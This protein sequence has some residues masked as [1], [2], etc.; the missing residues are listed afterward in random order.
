MLQK[1]IQFMLILTVVAGIWMLGTK[2]TSADLVAERKVADNRFSVT[3]LSFVNVNTANLSQLVQFFTT[4]G[5]VPGGFDARTVRIEK[6]GELD[7]KY[8]LQA[9]KKSGDDAFCQ[10]LGLKIARRDLSVI[11]EGDLFDLSIQDTLQD[12]DLEEWIIL[13][14]FDHTDEDLKQKTCEFDLY[15]RTYRNDPNE[16]FKGL[17]ATRTLTN[18]VTSG[19]W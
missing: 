11:Y 3:T 18:T 2:N 8:S 4:T 17:Y 6:Q 10:A 9:Q 5:F 19:T 16:A 12:G 15:M 1:H 14:D 7:V 13:L